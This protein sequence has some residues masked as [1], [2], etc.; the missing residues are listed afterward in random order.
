MIGC[1]GDRVM[2]G[3]EGLLAPYEHFVSKGLHNSFDDNIRFLGAQHFKSKGLPTIKD[4]SWKYTSLH[5]L[6]QHYRWEEREHHQKKIHDLDLLAQ[7]IVFFNGQW[8]PDL[9]V[10]EKGCR[11]GLLNQ[12]SDLAHLKSRLPEQDCFLGLAMAYY[13]EAYK[14]ELS[15]KGQGP[16]GFYSF[17]DKNFD[18]M[19]A[20]SFDFH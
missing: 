7:R 16:L 18:G 9:T 8:R 2:G 5:P 10:L 6:Q 14:L 19:M 12:Q 4:E 11:W 15:G 1:Q 17:F 3:A 20:P 13:K